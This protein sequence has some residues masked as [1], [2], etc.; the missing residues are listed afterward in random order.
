[1]AD[2]SAMYLSQFKNCL[3][4]ENNILRMDLELRLDNVCI[5]DQVDSICFEFV[6]MTFLP[7]SIERHHAKCNNWKINFG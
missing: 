2:G 7:F 4:C 5:K 3:Q 1:M 6:G